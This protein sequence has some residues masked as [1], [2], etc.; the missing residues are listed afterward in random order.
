MN[1][2]VI[3]VIALVGL[4]VAFSSLHGLAKRMKALTE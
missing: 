2:I 1:S 3:P 4:C